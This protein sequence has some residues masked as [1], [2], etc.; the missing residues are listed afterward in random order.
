M[1]VLALVFGGEGYLT[2]GCKVLSYTAPRRRWGGLKLG[3]Q[4][5]L[6]GRCE[7]TLGLKTGA[8]KVGW[9]D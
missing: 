6:F 4:E 2:F 7:F 9:M 5:Y 3:M 8:Q 1:S